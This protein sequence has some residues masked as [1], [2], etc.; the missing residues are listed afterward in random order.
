MGVSGLQNQ[1]EHQFTRRS[2]ITELPSWKHI[3][4]VYRNTVKSRAGE[5]GS[6]HQSQLERAA[7][8]YKKLNRD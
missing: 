4:E 5:T 6:L 2:L 8:V 1:Q 7:K 3:Q